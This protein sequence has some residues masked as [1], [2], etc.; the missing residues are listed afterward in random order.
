M[1][2]HLRSRESFSSSNRAGCAWGVKG[3]PRSRPAETRRLVPKAALQR[4]PVGCEVIL[5]VRRH[6]GVNNG[7]EQRSFLREL[8]PFFSCM[9]GTLAP[10]WGSSVRPP[11]LKV[12]DI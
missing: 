1:A 9:G 3:D 11:A 2:A 5:L 10:I 7:L 4:L 12:K 8:R 6:P